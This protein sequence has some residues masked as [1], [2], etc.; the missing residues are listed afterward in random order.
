MRLLPNHAEVRVLNPYPQRACATE[1]FS[2][3]SSPWAAGLKLSWKSAA[4]LFEFFEC[5]GY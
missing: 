2:L 4:S 3:L 5:R 1:R